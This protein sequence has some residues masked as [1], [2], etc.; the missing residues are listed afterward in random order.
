MRRHEPSIPAPPQ[1]DRPGDLWVCGHAAQGEA[2]SHGPTPDGRCP[3]L[4]PCQ[5]A[6]RGKGDGEARFRCTRPPCAGGP[7]PL[8]PSPDGRCGLTP[9]PCIPRRSPIGRR[10]IAAALCIATSIGVVLVA[11]ASPSRRDWFAPGPLARPHAQILGRHTR[12]DRCAACHVA[13]RGRLAA[14]FGS[15]RSGHAGV[16][17]SQLCMD[18]H[19]ATLPTDRA[20]SAHN[21]TMDELRKISATQTPG[22]RTWHDAMPHPPFA[23]DN[24]ECS[25]CHREHGGSAADLTLVSSAQCQ[26]CH[27]DRF[28]S[29]SDGHPDWDRWP[30]GRGGQI[31]FD[32]GAHRDGH[33][34]KQ[35]EAFD[36]RSCH[37]VATDGSIARTASFE[38]G[39]AACHDQPLRIDAN[40]GIELVALPTLDLET[41]RE[42]A[43]DVGPW[44][45]AADGVDDVAIPPLMRMLLAA[46]PDAAA[47]I[48]HLTDPAMRQWDGPP[49]PATSRAAAE[50]AAAT[51]QLVEALAHDTHGEIERRL[52][53]GAAQVVGQLS[54]QTLAAAGQRWFA[55]ASPQAPEESGANVDDATPP[56]SDDPLPASGDLLLGDPLAFGATADPL[57][58]LESHSAQSDASPGAGGHSGG[59]FDPDT[60]LPLGGWY[61]D[62][63]RLAIRYR[64]SGHADG[65]LRAVLELTADGDL[66]PSQRNALLAVP[67]VAACAA[68]HVGVRRDAPASWRSIRGDADRRTFTRFSHRPHMNLPELADCTHCHRV[69]SDA[70]EPLTTVSARA[71]SVTSEGREPRDFAPLERSACAGCHTPQAAG[72]SC[73]TCHRYHLPRGAGF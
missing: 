45:A 4:G 71:L 22:E 18:C 70:R 32:H 38:T 53:E 64:A 49:S 51:H 54:P 12:N 60:A 8:G 57:G 47:A 37:T 66:E 26:S 52:G 34:A 56:P 10:R 7:C 72:D 23:L 5:P 9:E 63:V 36:C 62:D 68:C 55:Q 20:R 19:H 67:A 11:L 44:P 15:G 43:L 25:A 65:V 3:A 40:R 73:T 61:R 24:V 14:W 48:D 21:L 31:A 39:C 30:Y 6:A 17:Q 42:Q 16:S 13:A 58:S 46:D 59:P 2:C 35:G 27:S 50:L 29:F 1:A 33:F 28:A 41:A 69:E